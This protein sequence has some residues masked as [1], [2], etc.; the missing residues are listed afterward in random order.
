M[1]P[2][3]LLILLAL[4]ACARQAP[5]PLSAYRDTTRMIG[6]AALFDPARFVGT[7]QVV[8]AYPLPG[9]APESLTYDGARLALG[10]AGGADLASDA[11]ASGPGRFAVD[12]GD[13]LPVPELWV[14]WADFDYRT[15]V[16]GAP[17]GTVGLILDRQA[18]IP[19]DRMA[20]AREMLDFNGYDLAALRDAAP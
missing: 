9:C 14:I 2:L 18:T 1:R 5:P 7:W 20:A 4:A 19:A 17:D 15:V 12:L 16:I 11:P 10:C 8:A 3:A 13:A 6:S